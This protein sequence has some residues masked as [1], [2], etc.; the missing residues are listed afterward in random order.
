MELPNGVE[1]DD[2]RS[3]MLSR[4]CGSEVFL[5]HV[6]ESLLR[7]FHNDNGVDWFLVHSICLR[8]VCANLGMADWPPLDGHTHGV[9]IRA[10]GDNA[11][12]VLLDLFGAIVFLDITSK[13]AQKLYEMRQEDGTLIDRNNQSESKKGVS[14]CSSAQ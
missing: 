8:E 6:K 7:I 5:I 13:Q 10:V 4:G 11:K 3:I 2:T 12:F 1:N 14:S 9:K